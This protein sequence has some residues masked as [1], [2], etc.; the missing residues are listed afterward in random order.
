MGF[1]AH[2]ALRFS[3]WNRALSLGGDWNDEKVSLGVVVAVLVTY[4]PLAN[5]RACHS[6]TDCYLRRAPVA[7]GFPSLSCLS[8]IT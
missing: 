5:V 3:V 7:P 1:S 8:L 4:V 6:Y 2:R